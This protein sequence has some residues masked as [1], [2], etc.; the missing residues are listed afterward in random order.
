MKK[1]KE[2]QIRQMYLQW[3][4][5]RKKKKK[6]FAKAIST[7][8]ATIFFEVHID[9]KFLFWARNLHAQNI[10]NSY[11]N[12]KFEK[13]MFVTSI[14]L[15]APIKI[16]ILYSSFMILVFL[17]IESETDQILRFLPS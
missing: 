7:V 15:L 1:I 10:P 11:L 17:H 9:F 12:S 13:L 14:P 2:L 8:T 16:L 3:I 5:S 4:T 6:V